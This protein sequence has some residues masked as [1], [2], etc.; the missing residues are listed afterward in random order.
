MAGIFGEGSHAIMSGRRDSGSASCWVRDGGPSE[1]L[2][3]YPSIV[4]RTKLRVSCL[5]NPVSR[6]N[7]DRTNARPSA[8]GHGRTN[9]QMPE[10]GGKPVRRQGSLVLCFT[11]S[12]R[13]NPD[14]KVRH[15]GDFPRCASAGVPA[16]HSIHQ[17]QCA[18]CNAPQARAGAAGRV[19]TRSCEPRPYRW[20]GPTHA[21]WARG[22]LKA[23]ST[24]R[25][26]TEDSERND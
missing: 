15:Q 2:C 10:K 14:G 25:T 6:I 5:L 19:H 21:G 26:E 9:A 11:C 18:T 22:R 17:D 4:Q 16:T 7:R 24:G 12:A 8:A 3:S 23:V 1:L 20:E 13:R